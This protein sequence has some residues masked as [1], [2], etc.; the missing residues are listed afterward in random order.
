M[1]LAFLSRFAN[2]F[3]TLK[4]CEKKIKKKNRKPIEF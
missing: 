1:K 4:K 3:L 2:I